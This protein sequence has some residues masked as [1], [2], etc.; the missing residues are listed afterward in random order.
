MKVKDRN[1]EL[2]EM[3]KSKV[4]SLRKDKT[5]E[6]VEYEKNMH[7]YTF[8]PSITTSTSRLAK[9]RVDQRKN[10]PSLDIPHKPTKFEQINLHPNSARSNTPTISEIDEPE[11][12]FLP[13]NSHQTLLKLNI[14]LNFK[15]PIPI[16]P[17]STLNL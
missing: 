13:I 4:P 7:E 14:F 11:G 6:E 2:F 8:T 10:S 3:S 1:L 15:N 16:N 9:S 12:K 5:T 17:H